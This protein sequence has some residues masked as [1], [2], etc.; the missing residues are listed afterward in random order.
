[1]PPDPPKIARTHQQFDAPD[2]QPDSGVVVWQE[3]DEMHAG[4]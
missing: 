1:M 3:H 4:A 2:Q